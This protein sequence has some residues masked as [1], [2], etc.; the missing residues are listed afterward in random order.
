MATSRC[1]HTGDHIV[2]Y[3]EN[4]P[5]G[6]PLTVSS[7]ASANRS[8]T[9]CSFIVLWLRNQK[10]AGTCQVVMKI[11]QPHATVFMEIQ[12]PGTKKK[13]KHSANF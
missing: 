2:E 1:R 8:A 5:F 7:S 10:K 9:P 3:E 6:A 4:A 11:L 12:F 13:P